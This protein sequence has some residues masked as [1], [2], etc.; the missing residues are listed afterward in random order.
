MAAIRK[1]RIQVVNATLADKIRLQ[2]FSE[3]ER[4]C[5]LIFS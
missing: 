1:S 2:I 3:E 5:A 4:A